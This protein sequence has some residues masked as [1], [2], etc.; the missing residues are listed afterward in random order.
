LCD[1]LILTLSFFFT[2]KFLLS[3]MRPPNNSFYS[4]TPFGFPRLPFPP[5]PEFS[6]PSLLSFS[7]SRFVFFCYN[8]IV[9]TSPAFMALVAPVPTESFDIF[10]FF[11]L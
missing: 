9:I 8:L 4:F 1:E 11:I 2:V 10:F 5:I 3:E 7:F 6:Y